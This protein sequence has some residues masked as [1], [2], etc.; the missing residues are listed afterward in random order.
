[1]IINCVYEHN[2]GDT[3]LYAADFAGAYTRGASL[4]I[5]AAKMQRE[6]HIARNLILN[7]NRKTLCSSR[8]QL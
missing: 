2:K 8:K 3:L 1:M 5:A 4:D 7:G 6:I